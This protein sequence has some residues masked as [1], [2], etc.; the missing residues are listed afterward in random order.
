MHSR[1]E[2]PRLRGLRERLPLYALLLLLIVCAS[3]TERRT[4]WRPPVPPLAPPPSDTHVIPDTVIPSAVLSASAAPLPPPPPPPP[5]LPPS[6]PR[7]A[8]T[9]SHATPNIDTDAALP[10]IERA[11]A[12]GTFA[13]ATRDESRERRAFQGR[14]AAA[15]E[16]PR[17]A[18]ALRRRRA[19]VCIFACFLAVRCNSLRF[20]AKR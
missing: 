4:T 16:K 17:V 3:L 2:R 8:D 6:P 1:R 15:C 13:L 14:A 10:S 12:T 19:E 5:P 20:N 11:P 18:T 7:L 9:Q